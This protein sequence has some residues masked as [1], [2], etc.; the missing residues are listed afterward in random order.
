MP[1]WRTVAI[2][3][4]KRSENFGSIAGYNIRNEDLTADLSTEKIPFYIKVRV[5][6]LDVLERFAAGTGQ[7]SEQYHIHPGPA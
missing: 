4:K 5:S 3:R 2:Y 6:D 1:H 7:L